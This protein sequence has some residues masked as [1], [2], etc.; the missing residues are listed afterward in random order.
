MAIPSQIQSSTRKPGA[1]VGFDVVSGQRGL[2]AINRRIALLGAKSAAGT[3]TVEEPILV[4]SRAESEDLFGQ[5]SELDLMVKQALKTAARYGRSPAIYGVPIADAG[6]AAAAERTFTVTGSATEAGDIVFKIAGRQ[7]RAGVAIGDSV[8]AMAAAMNDAIDAAVADMPVTGAPVVGVL[9]ASA[10]NLGVNGNAIVCEVVSTPAG[11]SIAVANSVAG[12]GSYDIT[13]ALDAIAGEHYH[14]IAVA[15]HLA[16]DFTDAD[17]HL[18]AMA[19]PAAKKWAF[20][21]AGETGALATATALATGTNRM[22]Q[23]VIWSENCRSL[24]GEI[25]AAVAARLEG[26]ENP[27]LHLDGVEL[28]LYQPPVTS[29]PTDA[30]IETALAAGVTPLTPNKNR[31]RMQIVRLVTTKTTEG[32]VPFEATLDTP[33]VRTLY[34]VGVQI[35]AA[36]T[37]FLAVDENKLLDDDAIARLRDLHYDVLK[38]GEALRYLHNVDAHAGELAAE[39]DDVV[40]TK[41]NTFTPASVIPGLHQVSSLVGLFIEAPIA[42]AA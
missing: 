9:T 39:V 29:I 11:V 3:A 42:A 24:P 20:F 27:A 35:D 15:N 22:D 36:T 32:G 38:Q 33:H 18:D 12:T 31:D 5:G 7:L 40:A 14:S 2:V 13:N 10:I 28:D 1:Y 25:A 8:T 23:H 30:E 41:V 26:Q 37:L 21:F 4:Q 16:A 34:W 19:L 17:A 6:G